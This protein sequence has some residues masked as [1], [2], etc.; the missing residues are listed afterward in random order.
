LILSKSAGGS[1][2]EVPMIRKA[3]IGLAVLLVLVIAGLLLAVRFV[4]VDAYRGRLVTLVKRATGRDLRINGG[5]SLSLVPHVALSAKD[6]A[7]ANAP[8]GQAVNMAQLK[9]L[10][11]QLKLL[12]LLHGELVVDRFDLVDPVIALEVDKAGHPNWVF[13]PA[14]APV[15]AAHAPPPARQGEAGAGLSELRLDD[16]ELTNGTISYTNLQTGQQISVTGIG[17]KVSL[18]DLES[19]CVVD[20]SAVWNGETVSL[21]AVLSKPGALE[22]GE[23]MGV[24]LKLQSRPINVAFDGTTTGAAA[25]RIDGTIDLAVP[26]VREL[27]KWMGHPLTLGGSGFGP[28]AVK[29]KI[30]AAGTRYGFSDASITLDALKTSGDLTVDTGGARPFAKG[31]LAVEQL[32]VN[33]YLG[34]A[35]TVSKPGAGGTASGRPAA[36]GWSDE[37][38]DVAA[39]K[40][41]DADLS[42]SADAI[43]YRK[44][45]LG[46][47]ALTLQLK[48]G[49]L[50]AD[51]SQ[52]TLYGGGGHGKLT[53]DGTATVPAVQAAFSLAHVQAEPLLD[54]VLGMDRL[55]GTGSFDV[56]LGS[57][58][59]SERELVA[60]L[61]GR[62]SLNLTKG[63]YKGANL[64]GLV[65]NTAMP[66]LGG[67]ASGEQTDIASLSA[68]YVIAKGLIKNNDL[69][70]VSA[71][72]PMEGAGTIDLPQRRVDYRVTPRLAGAIAVPVLISGPWDQLSYRPDVVGI[73]TDPA[74]AVGGLV[75]AGAKGVGGAVNGVANPVGG[76]L[77]G[78]LGQ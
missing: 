5:M 23:P 18:P 40:A 34:T 70:L 69:K 16:V 73:V 55:S 11:I 42:L 29:G 19:P 3:L 50:D 22:R 60:G 27:A 1:R 24:A 4:P 76:V 52:I 39:L 45:A 10:E 54:A 2:E 12:P 46:K 17:M 59:R 25:D 47:S 41:V 14:A 38:V 77:K 21:A 43:T 53:V 74:K 13:A 26:S 20:G 37:P 15:G 48:D 44:I 33:P 36:G 57:R 78:L 67:Q 35:P 28:L 63:A 6:V 75:G 7:F 51:L 56:T 49:R 62:G 58:G 30:A 71:D 8:G 61:D 9:S 72:L 32:D 64:V 66:I 65:K 68:S 31:R